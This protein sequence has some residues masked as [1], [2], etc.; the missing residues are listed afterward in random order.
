MH[1]GSGGIELI[2]LI[3]H[4][5]LSHVHDR[6]AVK[7]DDI[8]LASYPKS[9]N[10]WIRFIFYNLLKEKYEFPNLATFNSVNDH[11]H[12]YGQGKITRIN[13]VHLIKTHKAYTPLLFY[14]LR[15]LLIIRNPL[16]CIPSFY[17]YQLGNE[18]LPEKVTFGEFLRD[19]KRGMKKWLSHYNSWKDRATLCYRY[20]DIV[21]DPSQAIM[22][23][24]QQFDLGFSVAEIEQAAE[25]SSKE[26]MSR[27]EE[28]YGRKN[29]KADYKFVSDDR[30]NHYR[31]L[32]SQEDLQYLESFMAGLSIY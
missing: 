10:T 25:M 5:L 2:N 28:R 29:R 23:I 12:E 9:G 26:S 1:I 6:I 4:K 22:K 16:D 14:P 31:D 7:A 24:C 30:N 17:K 11:M 20:E 19:E 3:V 18:V 13:G 27:V 21:H 8:L 32:Y 15:S